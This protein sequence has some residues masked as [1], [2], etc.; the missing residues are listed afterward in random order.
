MQF[1]LPYGI[2]N[3]TGQPDVAQVCEILAC[4][5]ENGATTLD[6]AAGYG[7]SEEVLGKA[8]KEMGA[9][10]RV[11]IVS[12]TKPVKGMEEERTD[13]NVLQWFRDSVLSSL[14][15]LG[16]ERLPLCL[17]HDTNDVD[18]M[19]LL[20]DL[21]QEGLVEHVGV[22]VRTPD[23]MAKVLS[24]PGVEAIQVAAN[25]LD[26]RILRSGD[27]ARAAEAGLAVFVRSVYLQG[28]LVIP[29]DQVI[30]EL[31]ETVPVLQSLRGIAS[32]AGLTMPEMALRYGLSLP[33]ATGVLTGVE[34]VEQIA[35][36]VAIVGQ[37]PLASDV[38]EAIGDVVPDLPETILFPWHWPG[39]M[40]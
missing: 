39:A 35:A 1:G 8:L 19:H 27:L 36:N 6:T 26:Q 3:R 17:F 32:D 10:D 24:T 21:K 11:T 4:A 34:T 14:Q 22:S 16:I 13:R 28:L 33:G 18:Y 25:M 7:Q 2:A 9:L 20:C 37:G 30:P 40:R 12:K 5:I 29:L 38:V 23:Q 31:Q 15:L